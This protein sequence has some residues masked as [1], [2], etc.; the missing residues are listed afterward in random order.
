MRATPR[1]DSRA[2]RLRPVAVGWFSHS[3]WRGHLRIK[4]F[5]AALSVVLAGCSDPAAGSNGPTE[6][7]EVI[8]PVAPAAPAQPT[9]KWSYSENTDQMRGTSEKWANF[10][11]EDVVQ[12]NWPYEQQPMRLVIR[13]R[14]TD[15]V[16]VMLQISGQFVCRSYNGTKITAKFDD[17]PLETFNCSEA[18]SG[19]NDVVFITPPARFINRLKA[20][21]VMMLEAPVYEIGNVQVTFIVEGLEWE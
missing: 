10:S 4:T 9:F 6:D 3:N 16:N 8:E 19:P 5:I 2:Y 21:K 20:A 17:G 15:G 1:G 13:R 12:T 11:S 18:D 14:S 7:V